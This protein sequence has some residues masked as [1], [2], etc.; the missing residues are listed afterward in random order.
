MFK[1]PYQS[2]V[3]SAKAYV[4]GNL[5]G[6]N[7]LTSA[8]GNLSLAVLPEVKQIEK[9]HLIYVD[10]N[11]VGENGEVESNADT[12]I[13]IKVDGGELLGFGSARAISEESFDAGKYTSFYGRTQAIIYA[14]AKGEVKVTASADGYS[15]ATATVK[16]L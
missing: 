3:L 14:S 10:V 4:G 5:V 2:G 8:T 12:P 11:I 15:D 9:G 6:E 1:F 13:S 16:V 7:S